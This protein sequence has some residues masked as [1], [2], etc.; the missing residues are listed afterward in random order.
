MVDDPVIWPSLRVAEW[1][2]THD[3]L[4]MWPQIVDKTRPEPPGLADFILP[5]E[6]VRSSSSPDD[7]VLDFYA[8]DRPAWPR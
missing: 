3:T 6:A 7:M 8:L 5:W 4:H 2:D 1:R